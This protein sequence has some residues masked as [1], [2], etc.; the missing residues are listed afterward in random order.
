MAAAGGAEAMAAQHMTDWDRDA[1]LTT[2][3]KRLVNPGFA[4]NWDRI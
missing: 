2:A 3:R 1:A 4:P